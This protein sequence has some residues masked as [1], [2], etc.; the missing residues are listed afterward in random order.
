LDDF[1]DCDDHM[2]SIEMIEKRKYPRLDE[3]WKMTYRRLDLHDIEP[4]S[5]FTLNI[6]GGGACFSADEK[7]EPGSLIALELKSPHLLS[8]IIA[9]ARVIWCR[10]K[11]LRGKYDIGV[12][13][14]W[15]GW[16]DD[17]AQETIAK[18]IRQQL[19]NSEEFERDDPS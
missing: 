12:E 4:I 19:T 5:T 2:R 9:I 18:Y 8:P 7:L 16:K 14:W 13:F 1:D 11:G 17:G 3:N 15:I 6:S 10:R